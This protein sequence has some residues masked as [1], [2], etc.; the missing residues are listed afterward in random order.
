MMNQIDERRLSKYG[1]SVIVRS[2]G[3]SR[4]SDI[5]D[6][7]APLLLEFKPKCILLHVATNDATSKSADEMVNETLQLNKFCI[8]IIPDIHVI[9]S[10]PIMRMDNRMANYNI[11]QFGSMMCQFNIHLLNNDNITEDHLGK[12]GL[13]LSRRGVGRLALNIISQIRQL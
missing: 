4:I 5:F 9:V 1:P 11:Q 10:L 12:K 3:G 13:H 7:A 8:E 6:I 2:F